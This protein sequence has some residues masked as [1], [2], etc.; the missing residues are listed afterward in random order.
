M[1][2]MMMHVCVHACVCVCVCVCVCFLVTMKVVMR[3][4]DLT[5]WLFIIVFYTFFS[6][7]HFTSICI[8]HNNQ[9]SQCAVKM[10]QIHDN[11]AFHL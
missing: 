5:G 3:T 7:I 1:A 11:S 10:C 6:A 2:Q 9:E 4:C 8:V